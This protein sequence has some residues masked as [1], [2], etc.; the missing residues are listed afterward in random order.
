MML[1]TKYQGS[2][3]CDFRQEDFKFS[4]RKSIFSL[5][6]QDINGPEPFEQLFKE[7]PLK[8]IPATFV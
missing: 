8:I 6:D 2:G 4:S 7:D 1:L 5:C 3:P